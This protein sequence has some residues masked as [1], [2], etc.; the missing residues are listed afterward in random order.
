M[1]EEYSEEQITELINRRR[2]QVLIHSCLYY[3]MGT[4]LWTDQ[5]FDFAAR[6]LVGLQNR[7]PDIA[8]KCVFAEAFADFDAST[9]FDLPLEDP[10]V[11]RTA[12][13]LLDYSK[14]IAE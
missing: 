13:R 2:R 5:Q 14:S 6:Q 10:W 7:F 8:K 1:T 4:S 11:T 3:R 12:L 9:G